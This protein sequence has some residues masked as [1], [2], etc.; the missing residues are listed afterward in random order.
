MNKHKDAK[1][2][3]HGSDIISEKLRYFMVPTGWLFKFEP[4]LPQRPRPMTLLLVLWTVSIPLIVFMLDIMTFNVIVNLDRDGE[5][6]RAIS[7]SLFIQRLSRIFGLCRTVYFGMFILILIQHGTMANV[8]ASSNNYVSEREQK[9]F[10][11][12]SFTIFLLKTFANFVSY[13]A[14]LG[15]YYFDPERQ[16]SRW[17]DL[18]CVTILIFYILIGLLQSS[19]I[20]YA[21]YLGAS[22]GKHVE[23]FSKIYVDTMFDQF[24]KAIESEG[25]KEPLNSASL[26]SDGDITGGDETTKGGRGC[27]RSCC[28]CCCPYLCVLWRYLIKGLLITWK[29]IRGV[30]ARLNTR[31][32]PELPEMKM[33]KLSSTQNIQISETMRASNSHVIRI[34]L[35]RTQIMLS[36]LRDL[37]SDIDKTTSPIVALYLVY[38][39]M[40]IILITT[41]SIQAKVYRSIDF[42]I[43]PTVSTTIGLII[44]VIYICTCLDETTKQLKLMINKLFD[45][46]IMNHRVQTT[47]KRAF[48]AL[49]SH[50]F[51]ENDVC[52]I[53]GS[54]SG[55]INETWS[56][57]QYTRKL[58]NTIQFT[59]FGILPVTR[60][61]VLS[62]LGHIL[63]AV[64]IS[65]EIMSI[66]DTSTSAH[67]HD[68]GASG[69]SMSTKHHQQVTFANASSQHM[70]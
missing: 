27:L 45:F 31:Y 12:S 28:C 3:V 35:R 36:E 13:A 8:I 21:C 59:M 18:S 30:G 34:R 52:V 23:N 51:N 10:A 46:I 55:A 14:V 66:I 58:A 56:Q 44:S 22:L 57:F 6:Y 20:I 62:I 4:T 7:E 53:P 39:T 37:V 1:T 25:G 47:G 50:Q 29:F 41:S 49:E 17:F 26:W 67:G 24:M 63:S 69:G 70:A 16:P 64:F 54:E 43:M 32:Y 68:G 11:R 61:L 33:T 9:H 38:E 48:E 40:L 5:E 19:P 15:I 60:R 65:I 2:L 42:L